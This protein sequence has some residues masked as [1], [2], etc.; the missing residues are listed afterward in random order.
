MFKLAVVIPVFDHEGAIAEVARGVLAHGLPCIL[1]DDGSGAACAR[2]L[3]ELAAAAPDRVTLVRRAANGGKGAAVLSGLARARELGFTHALQIDADGQHDLADLPA[4]VALARGHPD[5]VIAGSAVFDGSVPKSRLYGRMV[6]HGLVWLHTLS[7]S[8]RDA[9][10]GFRVYPIAPVLD[11]A[12][13]ARVGRR[14]DFDI[15]ILVRL[16]WQRRTILSR[17]TKVR[18]P[19]DGVSH[20]RLWHDNLLIARLHVML[21]LGMLVRFPRLVARHWQTQ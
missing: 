12:E 21:F 7:L 4:F 17:P 14:M 3:D 18:Y 13:Q 2:V 1:V 6:T 19:L 8:I 15:E 10:C 20:F 5:A 16:Y 9:M 11:L